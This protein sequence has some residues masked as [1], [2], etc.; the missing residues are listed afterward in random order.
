MTVHKARLEGSLTDAWKELMATIEAVPAEE[1]ETPGVIEEWSVKDL[2]GHLTFWAEKAASDLDLLAEG[3]PDEIETPGGEENVAI[4][5]KRESEARKDMSLD[6]IKAGWLASHERA[7]EALTRVSAEQLD[8]EVAGWAQW[9]RYAGDTYLHYRE[10]TEQIRAW[11]RALET[12][13][14]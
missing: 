1:M 3:K 5:N 7:R 6:E 9:K 10:H 12:T 14:V 8:T 4:W 2:L 13:E 11:Q